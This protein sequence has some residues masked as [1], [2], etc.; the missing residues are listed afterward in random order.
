MAKTTGD[1]IRQEKLK[2]LQLTIG[3]IEKD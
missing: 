1:D 2:A 3:K